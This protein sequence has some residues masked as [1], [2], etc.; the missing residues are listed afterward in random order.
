MLANLYG[1]LLDEALA[2]AMPN[3]LGVSG[4]HGGE[5]YKEVRSVE[6]CDEKI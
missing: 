5:K 2:V 3:R 4:K 1:W 6:K